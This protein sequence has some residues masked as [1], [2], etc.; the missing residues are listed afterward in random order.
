MFQKQS[1]KQNCSVYVR[2]QYCSGLREKYGRP[3]LYMGS[4]TVREHT[5]TDYSY[6]RRVWR[7]KLQRLNWSH[8]AVEQFIFHWELSTS[9]QYNQ[10]V[11]K[12]ILLCHE[13]DQPYQTV[14]DHSIAE[15]LGSLADSSDPKSKI[16]GTLAALTSFYEAFDLYPVS[17]N[18]RKSNAVVKSST[19]KPMLQTPN[20]PIKPFI[21]LFQ[22]WP[23]NLELSRSP[24]RMK[25][26]CLLALTLM[27]RPS[28]L[29]PKSLIFDSSDG[30]SHK[31]VFSEQ[32]IHFDEN[33]G[34][35]ILFHGIKN[36]YDRDGFKVHLPAASEE[37]AQVDPIQCL[38]DYMSVT[39]DIRQSIPDRPVLL[40]VSARCL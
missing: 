3:D 40:L 27:L 36:D 34:M 7:Q 21:N 8:R 5:D 38:K 30:S 29:A 6:C 15:Y 17:P 1:V 26:V 19:V 32:Q 28:D 25:C 31:S 20:M 35:D 11:E 13:L 37:F 4:S 10:Y 33:G 18:I 23:R 24:L 9:Y 22:S 2:Q 12:F 14:G 16:N 39:Q